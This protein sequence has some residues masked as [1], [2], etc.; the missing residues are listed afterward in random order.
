M[1]Y[2]GALEW[3][4]ARGMKTSVSAGWSACCSGSRAEAIRAKGQNTDD[5][6][7]VTCRLCLRN[8]FK[9]GVVTPNIPS[10]SA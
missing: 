5:P 10:G 3:C 9:A 6:S 7:R 2:A 1:H 8:M 4:D